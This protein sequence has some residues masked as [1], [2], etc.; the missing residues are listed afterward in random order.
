M[1]NEIGHRVRAGMLLCITAAVAIGAAVPVLAATAQPVT[2]QDRAAP[3]SLTA[4]LDR[5]Q[6]EDML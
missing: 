4:L 6:I 1:K 3:A 2:D 5:A